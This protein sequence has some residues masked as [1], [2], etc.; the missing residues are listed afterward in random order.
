MITSFVES[1]NPRTLMKNKPPKNLI[2]LWYTGSALL[3][4]LEG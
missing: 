3:V 1:M 4:A 2:C